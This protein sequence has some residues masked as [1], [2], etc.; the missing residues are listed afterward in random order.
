MQDKQSKIDV[1]MHKI[2][3]MTKGVPSKQTKELIG[4]IRHVVTAVPTGKKLMTP[5]KKILQVKPQIVWWKDLPAENQ[6]FRDWITLLKETAREPT[7][8]KELVMGDPE[9]LGW[10][11]SSVEGVGGVCLTGKDAPEPKIW[12][13][14]SPNKL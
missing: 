6:A 9:F 14:K 1:D 12:R 4:K 10:V 8:S 11:D 7:T 5:I 3:G 2:V 13:L